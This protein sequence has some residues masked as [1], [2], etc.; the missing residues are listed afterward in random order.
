MKL[1]ITEKNNSPLSVLLLT[2]TIYPDEFGG[3]QTSM[4]QI[5]KQFQLHNIPLS[6]AKINIKKEKS[7]INLKA[8][9]K[10]IKSDGSKSQIFTTSFIKFL[11]R[12]LYILRFLKYSIKSQHSLKLATNLMK[13]VLIS[14]PILTK[15]IKNNHI[16]LILCNAMNSFLSIGF[17]FKMKDNIPFITIAHGLDVLEGKS[18]RNPNLLGIDNIITRTNYVKNLVINKYNINPSLFYIIPDGI[19]EEEFKDVPSREIVRKDLS[20]SENEFV[21][22]SVGRF[23]YRKGFDLVIKALGILQKEIPQASFKYLLCGFGEEKEK[24]LRLIAENKLENSVKICLNVSNMQRNKMLQAS[25]VLCM[26]SREIKGEDVEGFGIVFLEANYLE[27]PVIGSRTGGIP[28]AIE[29]N[30]T[31]FLVEQDDLED[32]CDKIKFLYLNREK[33][34]QMGKDGRKRILDSYLEEYIFEKYYNA[35][36]KTID[37]YKN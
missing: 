26:I 19:V 25:D 37:K 1:G 6:V 9:I 17:Y 2:D 8:T 3:I 16:N 28:E 14:L 32:L 30:K 10:F 5:F 36:K 21:I 12:P 11:L 34:K 4:Y 18:D 23:V 31:G 7:S 24:Y 33:G 13:K 35:F 29:E 22:I 15:F 20:I 27:V